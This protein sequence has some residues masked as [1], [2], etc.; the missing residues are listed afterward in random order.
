M[1]TLLLSTTLL[2]LTFGHL[3]AALAQ[4]LPKGTSGSAVPSTAPTTDITKDTQTAQRDEADPKKRDATELTIS[5]GAMQ[6]G[7][8]SRLLAA[9]GALGFRIRRD[10][11]QFKVNVAGNYGETAASPQQEW[12][13]NVENVQA[14]ER[15]DRFIG[16]WTVFLASQQ[17][18]DKFQGLDLRLQ[19]DPG[20]A[21]YFVNHKKELLWGELG[22]D[23]RYDIRDSDALEP[24]DANGKPI[25]G[26]PLLDKT[27]VVH[28]VRLFAGYETKFNDSV[29]FNAGLEYIQ[30]VTDNSVYRVNGDLALTAKVSKKLAVS[31]AFSERYENR[32]LPGKQQLD[33]ASSASLTYSFF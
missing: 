12:I 25:P 7:G 9:T 22:Y 32:P 8:N 29:K 16:N 15:Y 4:D 33:T 23:F 17:R 14:V 3:G 6:T 20:V 18:Q 11:D 19:I 27:T 21:Y 2:A 28:S 10:D 24:L 26:A 1:K 30:S 5:A 31:L 13:E